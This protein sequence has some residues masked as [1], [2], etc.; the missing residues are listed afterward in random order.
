VIHEAYCYNPDN[1]KIDK[2][3]QRSKRKEVKPVNSN[4]PASMLLN[5]EVYRL[6]LG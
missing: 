6:R 3:N 1:I 4:M 5:P 2:R